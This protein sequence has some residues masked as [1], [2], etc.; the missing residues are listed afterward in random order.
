MLAHRIIPCLGMANGRLLS[1]LHAEGVQDAGD[2]LEQALRYDRDGADELVILDIA[3]SYAAHSATL[4]VV[5]RVAEALFIPCAVGGGIESVADAGAALRAGADKIVVNRGAVRDPDLVSQ[6]AD[7]FGSQCVVV[8]VD[9]RRS[10]D[11]WAV[12]VNGGRDA[13]PLE[14]LSWIAELEDRGAGEILLTSVDRD[15]T[16]SGYDLALT[17]AAANAVDI[18]II[19]WGGAGSYQHFA[20]ALSAGAQGV[21]AASLFH[22]PGYT[23]AGAK[24][25]LRSQGIAVRP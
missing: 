5:Q 18:P 6:L 22:L 10:T 23:I 15:G 3:A 24:H 11:R 1:G 14:A 20:E 21:M 12:T 13:T 17:T 19:A 7:A 4:G 25:Y 2:P 16:R 9:V 8:A